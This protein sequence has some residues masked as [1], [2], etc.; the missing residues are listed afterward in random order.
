MN[1]KAMFWPLL[2]TFWIAAP[3]GSESR[4]REG[5][6]SIAEPYFPVELEIS[7]DPFAAFRIQWITSESVGHYQAVATIIKL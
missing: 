2:I 1:H 7:S 4:L 3:R 5:S 6:G